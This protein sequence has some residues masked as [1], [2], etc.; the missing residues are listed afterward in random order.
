MVQN[1][2]EQLQKLSLVLSAPVG[3]ILMD[4]AITTTVATQMKTQ[5]CGASLVILTRIGSYVMSGNA[6]IV[7]KIDYWD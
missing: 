1:T 2:V 5:E 3:K 6:L 7:T 4:K